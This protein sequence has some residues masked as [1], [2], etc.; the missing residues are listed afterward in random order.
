M[1][2]SSKKP[3]LQAATRFRWLATASSSC[4]S[5]LMSH[6]RA[7]IAACSPIDMPVRGSALRGAS[8]MT[9]VGRSLRSSASRCGTLFARLIC[10]RTRRKSSLTAIGASEAVSTPPAMP[11]S[12]WPSAILFAT[13]IVV[14][15][16][17]PQA[18][19]T[20]YAG[21]DGESRAPST[22]SRVRLK[23]RLCLRTAPPATSPR[24]ASCRPKRA[25]S[26]S[27]AAV[28]MSWLDARA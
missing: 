4:A 1:A 14:S 11:L 24:R 22:A 6:W 17:V 25:T 28:S 8:G 12:T 5:R 9:W 19:W 23:S 2:R 26:P 16:P 20:S 13:W 18:C 21:V 3:R 15:R 27:S 7:V 10:S